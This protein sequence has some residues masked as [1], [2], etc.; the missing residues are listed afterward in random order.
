MGALWELMHS[1]KTVNI[2]LWGGQARGQGPNRPTCR[3]SAQLRAP[4]GL[5]ELFTGAY[6]KFV[7][8]CREVDEPGLAIVAIDEVTGRA[9][10]LVRLR[11][12]I[13]RHVTAI[14]GRHDACDLFLDVRDQLA[15]RHLAVIVDPVRSWE[16]GAVCTYRILDLRTEDGFVDERGRGLRGVRCEGAAVLRCGGY[17]LFMLPLGDPTDWPASAADAW[18]CVPERIYFDEITHFSR[19]SSVHI[20][21]APAGR[22]WSRITSVRGPRDP[23][24]GLVTNGD[25]VG[26]L[27]LRGPRRC[28][29]IQLGQAAL[30]DGVLLGRYDRCDGRVTED[31]SLSRVHALLI[32]IDQT[33]LVIDTASTN[34]TSRLDGSAARVIEIGHGTELLFGTETCMRWRGLS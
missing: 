34:G 27:E 4:R 6:A 7:D 17:A 5:G 3:A 8:A 13:A 24:A 1:K 22:R 25:V 31:E 29:T 9:A 20:P 10:G 14:V 30:R 21:R 12:R 16:P 11:A 32:Q 18:A 28:Q 2:E 23:S 15:L 33:L 26:T 19:G